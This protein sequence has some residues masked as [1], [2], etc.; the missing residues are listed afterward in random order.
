MIGGIFFVANH[1]GDDKEGLPGATPEPVAEPE[2]TP[3]PETSKEEENVRVYGND[4]GISLGKTVSP[5]VGAVPSL[6]GFKTLIQVN[7]AEV[8]SYNRPQPISFGHADEYTDQ[9]GILTFGGNHYRNRFSYGTTNVNDRVIRRSWEQTVGAIG[10][11]GGTG[12]TGQP[13][14]IRWSDE[15]RP[16]LG[17]FDEYKQKEGFTEV[18]YPTMDGK[19]YFFDLESGAK[20]RSPIDTG[21]V[22]KSTAALDPRG[23][24]VL[25]V[26][27]SIPQQSDGKYQAYVMAFSLVTNEQLDRFGGYDYF[28]DRSWQAYDGSPLISNDTLIYGGENGVLYTAKLNTAFDAEAG[29][30]SINPERLVKYSYSG[31]GYSVKDAENVRWLGIES[32]VSC[33]ENYAYFTDNGGRLQCV[34]LNTMSLKLV[35]DV[36]EDADASVLIEENAAK[37]TILLYTASQVKNAAFGGNYGYTY[38]RCIN[39]LTGQILWEQKWVASTGDGSSSGGTCATPQVGRGNVSG[40]V[41]YAMNE[42]ALNSVGMSDENA[43]YS[44]GGKI[45]AY[46]KL[47]GDQAWSDEQSAGFRASPVLVYDENNR[48]Y[49]IL[50]DAAGKLRMYDAVSGNEFANIDLGS[51]IDSTPAVFDQYLVVGTRGKG[52]SGEAAKII[53]VKIS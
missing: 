16:V 2:Q 28:C 20:S 9:A 31:T 22:M 5:D 23:W 45:I 46:D 1:A 39:G 53:C 21:V 51:R 4:P 3:E 41:F 15:V 17:V 11:W 49:L 24:P 18:I 8:S 42:T 52:G 50:C 34:D 40:L 13:L 37:D 36:G 27:Q 7:R 47:T 33:F 26:G 44:L 43:S 25:Y 29:T 19:I 12:W 6:F 10:N 48:G 38:H 35:Q 14:I 32:S 30:V